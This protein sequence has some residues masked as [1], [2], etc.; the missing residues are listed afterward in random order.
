M[1]DPAGWYPDPTARHEL[2]YWDGYTWLDNVSDRGAAATDALGGK[3]MPPPS[4]AAAKAAS[5]PA[6]SSSSKTPLYLALGGVAVVV[7]IIVGIVATR[8]GGGGAKTTALDKAAVT[9]QDDTA[10][11]AHPSVQKVHIK[12]NT[13]VI[14][15]VTSSDQ[16]VTP[17]LVV[18][19]DQKTVDTVTAKVD[20]V[21]NLLQSQLRDACGN[22]REEDIGAKGTVVYD[23]GKSDN[24]GK[25][26]HSF[27]VVLAEGDY[28]F[29]P[30][31]VDDNAQCQGGKSTMKLE[32]KFLDFSGVKSIGDLQS[33]L[34]DD[35][36][37]S[38]LSG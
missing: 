5:G 11:V 6:A 14:V 36:D 35:S 25:D 27:M 33:T 37:L 34:S 8:G 21:K 12:D 26:F 38:S 22:L 4:E 9:F 28:E 32:P 10:D 18:L 19:A 31:L 29:V 30:V 2:R 13:V 24:P 1:S 15:T 23:A 17:G 7:I 20:G 16:K 3:P